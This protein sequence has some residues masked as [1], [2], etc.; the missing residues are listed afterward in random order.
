MMKAWIVFQDV[1]SAANALKA[2]QG[3]IFYD[4]PMVRDR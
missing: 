1:N 2:K 4:K 3:F